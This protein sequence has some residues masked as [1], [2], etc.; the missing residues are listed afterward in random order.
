MEHRVK[1]VGKIFMKTMMIVRYLKILRTVIGYKRVNHYMVHGMHLSEQGR[2]RLQ[3]FLITGFL[4]F[5]S[6]CV[7]HKTNHLEIPIYSKN[8]LCRSLINTITIFF[9]Q[10]TNFVESLSR[11]GSSTY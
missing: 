8:Q 4:E 1:I 2:N 5:F 7:T 3:R 11:D 10:V 6:V 9:M